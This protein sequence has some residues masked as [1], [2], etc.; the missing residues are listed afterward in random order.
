M[1]IKMGEKTC[2]EDSLR[3]KR[4]PLLA[5]VAGAALL[6]CTLGVSDAQAYMKKRKTPTVAALPSAASIPSTPA[7]PSILSVAQTQIGVRYRAGGESPST[8]FDCS[9]F[10]SWV[11]QKHGIDL[12]RSSGEHFKHGH[13]VGRQDLKPGD[14]VFFSSKRKKRVAHVGIYMGAGQ[15]IHAA[16]RNHQIQVNG[17][18]EKY[19]S[20]HFMGARRI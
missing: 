5:L 20:K 7:V 1:V 9:G 19:W 12:G 16:S 6:T 11:L 8:G 14:L 13:K 3:P 2:P 15:F 4:L 17:L 18:S 10:V